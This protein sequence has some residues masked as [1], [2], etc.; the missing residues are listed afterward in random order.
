MSKKDHKVFAA[1]FE[2]ISDL[3][4]DE[5][6]IIRLERMVSPGDPV[7]IRTY[8]GTLDEIAYL[9]ESLDQDEKTRDYYASTLDAWEN[10]LKGDKVALHQVGASIVPLLTPAEDVCR[11]AYLLDEV[12]WSYIDKHGCT[13]LASADSVDVYQSLVYCKYNYYRFAHYHFSKLRRVHSDKGWVD[14]Q[15]DDKG[16]PGMIYKTDDE[17][18][19]S[20]LYVLVDKFSSYHKGAEA[21]KDDQRIN[22]S[23]ISE[24][25]F[26]R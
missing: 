3:T 13:M 25:L 7:D 10:W 6:Y 20:W 26:I 18:I 12:E 5:C 15:V 1:S 17:M 21:T 16:V 22:Y 11:S 4:R 19:H 24:D 23:R 14:Y 9:I 8:C 2:E